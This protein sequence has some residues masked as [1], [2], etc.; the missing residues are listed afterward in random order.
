ML[1]TAKS[2]KEFEKIPAGSHLARCYMIAD[3][4]TQEKTYK[5]DLKLRREIIFV[6]ETPGKLMENGKPFSISE[7]F[8]AS[9][10]PKAALR[11]FLESWKGSAFAP[12]EEAGF[13]PAYFLSRPAYIS[14]VH[15]TSTTTGK[16][17][18]NIAAIMQLPDG[19]NA[20]P[21]VNGPAYFMLD[22]YT[23]ESFNSLP[24]WIQKK[25][26]NSPEYQAI[27]EGKHAPDASEVPFVDDVPVWNEDVAF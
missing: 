10:N 20:P 13:D 27:A 17:Y 1:L 4:G 6:F 14:V 15:D 24:E 26:K 12:Q 5:G 11:G 7:T 18:A 19:V 25:I 9:I 8:T 3:L 2:E 23:D 22:E 16:T 21:I